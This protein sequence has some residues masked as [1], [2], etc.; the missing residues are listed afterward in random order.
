MNCK[1]CAEASDSPNSDKIPQRNMIFEAQF[2]Y[3]FRLTNLFDLTWCECSSLEAEEKSQSFL[4]LSLARLINNRRQNLC[5]C[6]RT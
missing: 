5:R 4:F 6:S 2:D 3:S 1:F